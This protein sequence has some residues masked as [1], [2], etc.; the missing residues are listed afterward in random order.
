MIWGYLIAMLAAWLGLY[1]GILL[2]WLASEEL[3]PG[4]VYLDLLESVT[5]GIL[6][7]VAL[8]AL[9][10]PFRMAHYAIAILFITLLLARLMKVEP[11]IKTTI[12]FL[13]LALLIGEQ[14]MFLIFAAMLFINQLP[15]GATLVSPYA[16]G[17]RVRRDPMLLIKAAWKQ[18]W[19]ALLIIGVLV[20]YSWIILV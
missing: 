4:K 15:V 18:S 13:L 5:Y 11:F 2:S 7:G 1:T 16:S 9:A 8:I 19:G 10:Q 20:G 6:V 12:A 3:K 14:T 17:R